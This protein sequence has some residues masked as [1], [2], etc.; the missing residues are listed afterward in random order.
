MKKDNAFWNIV[1]NYENE[2]ISLFE[3]CKSLIKLNN[4]DKNEAIADLELLARN[5]KS[6]IE[7]GSRYINILLSGENNKF[8]VEMWFEDYE[9]YIIQS[10]WFDTP[11]EAENWYHNTFDYIDENITAELM[12]SI[13]DN[14]GNYGD[15]DTL[16]K[17]SDKR[18]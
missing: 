14:E 13:I 5:K 8:Y 16:T 4:N 18:W 12:Y 3:A 9:D 1:D 17:L 10:I 6:I 7:E 11:D 2:N 15:I